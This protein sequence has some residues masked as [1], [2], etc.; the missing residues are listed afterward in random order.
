MHKFKCCIEKARVR[1]E[2]AHTQTNHKNKTRLLRAEAWTS[3]NLTLL[4]VIM[5]SA[6]PK[7]NTRHPYSLAS[8]SLSHSQRIKKGLSS[9]LKYPTKLAFNSTWL[10]F[11][12]RKATKYENERLH[13]PS[14]QVS[15]C[16]LEWY[17]H[18][19]WTTE[20]LAAQTSSRSF[21][22]DSCL[23]RQSDFP[24]PS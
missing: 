24:V 12:A 16:P 21:S 18:L 8:P 23:I 4:S 22:E 13:V 11:I 9:S 15:R 14:R 10:G 19:N 6:C 5:L 1:G 20:H 7:I 2:Y 3:L 17:F